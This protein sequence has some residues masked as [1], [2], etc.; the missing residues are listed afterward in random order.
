MDISEVLWNDVIN[1]PYKK[2]FTVLCVIII[3]N[4]EL[5]YKSRILMCVRSKIHLMR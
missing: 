5:L 3:I 1:Y 4:C 2:D